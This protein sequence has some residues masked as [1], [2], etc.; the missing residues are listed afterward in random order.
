MV[1]KT[2][3]KPL[4]KEVRE[5]LAK[6]IPRLAST[7]DGEV[8]ATVNAIERILSASGFDFYDLVAAVAGSSTIPVSMQQEWE[9]EREPTARKEIYY[10]DLLNMISFIEAFHPRLNLR[11][12][13]FLRGLRRRCDDYTTIFMSPRQTA[14]L[15]SLMEETN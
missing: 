5:K 12:Q 4:S 13:D 15:D 7:S 11:S 9:R 1:A 10:V 8:V 14:W 6:I 3:T 2:V